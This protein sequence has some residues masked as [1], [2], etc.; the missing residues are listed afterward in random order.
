MSEEY[1]HAICSYIRKRNEHCSFREFIDLYQE[2]IIESP[3]DTDNWCSLEV[4]WKTRFLRNIKDIIPEKYNNI[5]EKVKSETLNRS[6]MNYWQNIINEKERISVINT[7]ISGSLKIL[8]ITAKH[9]TDVIISKVSYEDQLRKRSLDNAG[10]N[11]VADTTTHYGKHPSK[12]MTDVLSTDS[13]R[14]KVETD[15]SE[16]HNSEEIEMEVIEMVQDSKEIE[17]LSQVL[18]LL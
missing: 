17:D 1:Y 18:C 11:D 2:M 6:L 7:H 9:N 12:L 14:T 3:P 16:G 15:E 4:A 13:K 10:N 5:Y 8:D